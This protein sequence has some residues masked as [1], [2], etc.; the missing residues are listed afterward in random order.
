MAF[1]LGANKRCTLMCSGDGKAFLEGMIVEETDLDV[2]AIVE[3]GKQRFEI[4]VPT[5]AVAPPR[6]VRNKEH[7]GLPCSY[8]DTPF[9]IEDCASAWVDGKFRICASCLAKGVR[10]QHLS[11]WRYSLEVGVD[12]PIAATETEAFQNEAPKLQKSPSSLVLLASG[13]RSRR[14]ISASSNA[15]IPA[16]DANN[17]DENGIIGKV[18]RVFRRCSSEDG[19]HDRD[20]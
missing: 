20:A 18:T 10:P 6:N 9:T 14:R 17:G 4:A 12:D 19:S 2:G 3:V 5:G 1:R 16:I 7:L 13:Q 11:D 8:C 15:S